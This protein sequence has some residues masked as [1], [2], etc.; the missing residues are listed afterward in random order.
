MVKVFVSS[1][2]GQCRRSSVEFVTTTCDGRDFA[3][4]GGAS[5][6]MFC[7]GA[8][9]CGTPFM[10][11]N[12]GGVKGDINC[13]STVWTCCDTRLSFGCKW[14]EL[15]GEEVETCGGGGALSGVE[16]TDKA[17]GMSVSEVVFD[18]TMEWNVETVGVVKS[19]TAGER[20]RKKE[21]LSEKEKDRERIV[22]LLWS[23]YSAI[24]SS[25]W[26]YDVIVFTL[27]I[28]VNIFNLRK[29][30]LPW[31]YRHIQKPQE[32]LEYKE[33]YSIGPKQMCREHRTMHR[34]GP[35]TSTK[36]TANA[37]SWQL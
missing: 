5:C 32:L 36:E 12:D 21:I 16:F 33:H 30:V 27:L 11:D 6:R 3:G 10:S 35:G 34:S 37:E 15:L 8:C 13:I 25:G 2:S 7:L 20:Q 9:T 17:S 29:S 14:A 19:Y 1:S 23:S 4:G 26:N 31:R 24:K 28:G 18:W 22:T